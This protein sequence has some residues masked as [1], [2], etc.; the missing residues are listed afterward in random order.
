MEYNDGREK[1]TV[2]IIDD[3]PS[4]RRTIKNLLRRLGYQKLIE[5]DDGDT[6]LSQVQAVRP[7]LVISDWN[8]PRMNGGQLVRAIRDNETIAQTPF[9]VITAEVDAK[10][11]AEAAEFEVDA[12]IVAPFSAE[13]VEEKIKHAIAI[14]SKPSAVETHLSLGQV[15]TKARQYDA[16]LGEFEKVLELAPNSPRAMVAYG[17]VKE[18]QGDQGMAEAHYKKAIQISPL[19]IKGHE[20]LA[21]LY[22]EQGDLKKA[23][24]HLSKAVEISPRN[25]KRQVQLG[26]TLIKS[27]DTSKAKDVLKEVMRI[28]QQDYNDVLK[29]V[30][31]AYLEA[32]MAEEAQLVFERGLA[33]NPTDLHLYNRLGIA[34]RKQKKYSSAVANYEQAI[35]IDPG[36]ENLYYN[37]G[38]AHFENGNREKAGVAMRKA[39]EIYPDFDEAKQFI[40]KL[41]L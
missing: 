7:N 33:A 11:I 8:M 12:Y 18:L 40:A 36:S 29:E 39:I 19:F 20:S 10:A 6:G 35:R 16:A 41:G 14:R 28:A 4:M 1:L 30:G 2:L 32:G 27:G 15:Y 23:S 3:K 17:Q 13:L 24:K 38:R 9:L 21:H 31:E 26:K 37:L 34:Y 5:A 25:A 22:R